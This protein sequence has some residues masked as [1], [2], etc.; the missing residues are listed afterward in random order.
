MKR[1]VVVALMIVWMSPGVKGW[2][3]YCEDVECRKVEVCE[4]EKAITIKVL[5]DRKAQCDSNGG[6]ACQNYERSMNNPATKRIMEK[7]C[8]TLISEGYNPLKH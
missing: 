2:A 3:S 7:P 5:S 8:K 6:A 1:V 4:E